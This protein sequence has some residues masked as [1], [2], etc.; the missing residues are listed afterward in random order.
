M[1][2]AIIYR[3]PSLLDGA[4]IVAI[5]TGLDGKSANP[6]TG[7]LV[8]TWILRA[9]MGPTEA[10]MSG[11]DSSICGDCRHRI[12]SCYVELYRAPLTIWRRFVANGYRVLSLPEISET[13]AGK[14]VR[15]GTYG[16]P[17]AVPVQ[18]WRAY[19]GLAA[20]WT[21]YTHQWRE[22]LNLRGLCMA[23]VDNEKERG[24]A[25]A[26]GWRT[27]RVRTH[28]EEL[29]EHEFICPASTEGGKKLTCREC[30]RCGGADG[31]RGTPAIFVHGIIGKRRTYYW[32]HEMP[33]AKVVEIRLQLDRLGLA[34]DSRSPAAK[35]RRELYDEAAA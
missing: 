32:S 9:D 25:M 22:A 20:H 19:A 2:S 17:A 24:E 14:S 5:A 4:P 28:D 16:D 18:V 11:K 12:G 31:K 35:L 23:S 8:N 34:I 7:P 6:K 27:F 13:C 10:R 3:G 30:N 26:L 15:I 21:G 29:L 1:N 33:R